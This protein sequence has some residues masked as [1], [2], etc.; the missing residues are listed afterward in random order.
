MKAVNALMPVP[1]ASKTE[2]AELSM[3]NSPQGSL[4]Q[5]VWLAVKES[6]WMQG[7]RNR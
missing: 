2:L 6:R 3:T 5:G 1:P 7:K 4:T